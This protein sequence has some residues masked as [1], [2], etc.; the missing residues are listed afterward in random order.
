MT[1]YVPFSYNVAFCSE[2]LNSLLL[3]SIHYSKIVLVK[4]KIPAPSFNTQ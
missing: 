1:I 4:E 2:C 3:E